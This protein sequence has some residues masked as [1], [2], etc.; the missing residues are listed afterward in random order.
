MTTKPQRTDQQRKSI[1]VLC[2]GYA[3]LLNAGGYDLPAVLIKKAIPVSWSQDAVK[4]YLFKAV[5]GAL[6]YREDGSPKES[7]TELETHEVTMVHQHLDKWLNEEF[8]VSMPFPDRF[9]QAGME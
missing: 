8:N 5:M 6:C 2:N 1:E 7:T 3:D 4:E 9:T